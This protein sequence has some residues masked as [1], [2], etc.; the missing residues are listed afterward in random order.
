M[1]P[2]SQHAKLRSA[3]PT[4]I[5]NRPDIVSNRKYDGFAIGARKEEHE[6]IG[7]EERAFVELVITSMPFAGILT[8]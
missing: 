6:S 2:L 1:L 7:K 3:N 4:D 8:I 5:H